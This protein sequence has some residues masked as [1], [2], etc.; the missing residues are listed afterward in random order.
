MSVE[1]L[2]RLQR[3]ESGTKGCT[4]HRESYSQV[5]PGSG[6]G[7]IVRRTACSREPIDD[8]E[9]CSWPREILEVWEYPSRLEHVRRSYWTD[10]SSCSTSDEG[11]RLARETGSDE[12]GGDEGG[13][14]DPKRRDWWEK[15][16]RHLLGES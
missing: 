10:G 16:R 14:S 15:G 4:L 13:R 11:A 2:N 3:L 7:K 6:T 5:P 8:E 9:Y 1:L 12:R